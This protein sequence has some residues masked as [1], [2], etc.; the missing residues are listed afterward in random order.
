MCCACRVGM[1]AISGIKLVCDFLVL[2]I[3]YNVRFRLLVKVGHLFLGNYIGFMTNA[4]YNVLLSLNLIR[5]IN[6]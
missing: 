1:F 6:L 2:Q 5:P 4:W 3:K